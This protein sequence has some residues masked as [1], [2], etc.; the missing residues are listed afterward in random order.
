MKGDVDDL[1]RAL[2]TI[3]IRRAAGEPVHEVKAWVDT[4]F[5]GEL[6]VPCAVIDGLGLAQSEG[7]RARLA[8]GNEVTL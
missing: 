1:G 4:A 2:L 7:I 6:V 3:G 8:D 5:N